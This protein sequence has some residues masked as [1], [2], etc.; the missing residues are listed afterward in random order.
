[1]RLRTIWTLP[2]MRLS[3]RLRRTR[4]WGNWQLTAI[5]PRRLRYYT[6]LGEIAKA[7]RDSKNIPATPLDEILRNLEN[8][9]D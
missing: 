2:D 3:E 1:M 7:T 8:Q 6:T 4:E 9:V 5:L